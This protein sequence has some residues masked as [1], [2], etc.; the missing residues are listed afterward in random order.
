MK[1]IL[2]KK[3]MMMKLMMMISSI[4]ILKM[5]KN[6][7]NNWV[8]K[9]INRIIKIKNKIIIIV[10]NNRLINQNLI[11]QKFPKK[12]IYTN[13]KII[14]IQKIKRIFSLNNSW[15]IMKN[16]ILIIVTINFRVLIIIII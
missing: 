10:Y 3:M 9:I 11:C 16:L 12:L 5:K 13:L 6:N 15:I 2:K 4:S 14:K 1:K 8:C 7:L